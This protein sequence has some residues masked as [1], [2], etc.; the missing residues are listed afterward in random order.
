M[1]NNIGVHIKVKDFSKSFAFYN[2][3]GFKKVFEY[4]PDKSVVE[5]YNGTVFE[6]GGA[7]LEI[8]DGHR[9]VNHLVFE[10]NMPSSKISLMINVDSIDQVMRMAKKVGIRLAVGPRHYYWGTLEIVIKDPDGVVL[11][12]ISQYSKEMARRIKADETFSQNP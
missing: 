2:S 5:D 6:H 8:A 9:A 4:G 7:R 3:L 11:V 10:Q 1:I 12:F